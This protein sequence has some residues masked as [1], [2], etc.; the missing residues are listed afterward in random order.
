[1]K[2]KNRSFLSKAVRAFRYYFSTLVCLVFA[3]DRFFILKWYQIIFV[4][5]F[6][7]VT[8]LL[9]YG[10]NNTVAEVLKA[11]FKFLCKKMPK[12]VF[13]LFLDFGCR[14]FTYKM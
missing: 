12:G 3:P 9:L 8:M 13:F 4:M 14:V 10:L 11:L 1:M 6:R 7:A 2:K 5:V